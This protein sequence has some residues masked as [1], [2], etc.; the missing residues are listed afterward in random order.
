MA[1]DVQ[2]MVKD[3]KDWAASDAGKEYFENKYKQHKIREGRF[4][5]FEKY[6]KKIDFNKL[7]Y[8]LILEHGE[9]WCE[10][11]SS[12]GYE[13]YPNNKLQFLL[14]YVLYKNNYL[15]SEPKGLEC[16]FPNDVFKFKG[17]YFQLI[18]GQGTIIRIFNKEDK[19]MLLQV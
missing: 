13:V 1:L 5:R 19:K 7:M 10:K 6:I 12:N 11:C 15:K 17:Y 18:Y 3:M 2:K 9:D 14:D 8:R 16:D 4:E